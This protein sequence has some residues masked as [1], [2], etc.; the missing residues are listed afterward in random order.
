LTDEPITR[1]FESGRGRVVE[2]VRIAYEDDIERALEILADTASQLEH[3][4]ADPGPKAT[5]DALEN[6]AVLL[7]A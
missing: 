3:V 4:T 5:V 2:C 7:R 6:D 1:P